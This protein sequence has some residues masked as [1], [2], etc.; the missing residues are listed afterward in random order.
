MLHLL[1]VTILCQEIA[2]LTQ[3]VLGGVRGYLLCDTHCLHKCELRT[4]KKRT[5]LALWSSGRSGLMF[6]KETERRSD[7]V[8]NAS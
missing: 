6:K 7:P 4:L 1:W 2:S 3:H 8:T 5:F